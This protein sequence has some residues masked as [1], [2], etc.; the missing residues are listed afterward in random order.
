M[1]PLAI[2]VK[3]ASFA[4]AKSEV[5]SGV[6]LEVHEGDFVAIVGPNGGGKSTLMKLMVG[7]LKPSSGEVRVFGENVPSKHL[8]IGYVP[9]NTNHNLKFPITVEDCVATG[10]PHYRSNPSKV[11]EALATV[12]MSEFYGRK[13]GDLSGGERQRVLIARALVG[14]PRILFLDEPSSS[15]DQSGQEALYDLLSELNAKMTIVIVSHDLEAIS[16]RAKSLVSV[17]RSVRVLS[18]SLGCRG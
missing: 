14:D 6:N 4:Y 3:N 16:L 5:L 18:R 11:K 1:K 10:L 9:Q 2:E 7:L 13:L 8:S 17:N 15:I 12:K